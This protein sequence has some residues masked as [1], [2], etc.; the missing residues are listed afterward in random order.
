MRRSPPSQLTEGSLERHILLSSNHEDCLHVLD[1]RRSFMRQSQEFVV[2]DA[3][4]FSFGLS[5]QKWP[6]SMRECVREILQISVRRFNRLPLGTP[7]PSLSIMGGSF[8]EARNWQ[9]EFPQQHA[10][11][12][13]SKAQRRLISSAF[14]IWISTIAV[15]RGA[16]G[17]ENCRKTRKQKR[18][19][20]VMAAVRTPGL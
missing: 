14:D 17:R 19:P 13:V 4:K 7:V 8:V 1:Q 6:V 12:G 18:T 11:S 3:V 16:A 5:L 20:A 15:A 10:C 2:A 9:D